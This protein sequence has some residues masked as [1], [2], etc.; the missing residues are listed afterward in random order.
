MNEPQNSKSYE[1]ITLHP[2]QRTNITEGIYSW[3]EANDSVT[4]KP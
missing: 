4:G 1:T 2:K 3:L